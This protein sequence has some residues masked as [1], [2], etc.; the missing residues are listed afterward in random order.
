M[1]EIVLYHNPRC[2]KSRA[3]LALLEERGNP[4]RIV[5]YLA[6]PPG[7]DELAQLRERLA[8]D[9]VSWIR[10]KESVFEEAGLSESSSEDELLA[11][12]EAHPILLERPIAVRGERAV[13]GRPPE[14]VLELLDPAET[15]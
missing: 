3:A 13:I 4:L 11:A 9:P 10:S 7:R 2:S 1:T 5:E 14:R 12:V 6:K 8:D 15:P